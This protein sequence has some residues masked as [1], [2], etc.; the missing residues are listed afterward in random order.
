MYQR[1]Y[2]RAIEVSKFAL[3]FRKSLLETQFLNYFIDESSKLIENFL[4]ISQNNSVRN[5]VEN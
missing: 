4:E 3:G 2:K 1:I 5:V